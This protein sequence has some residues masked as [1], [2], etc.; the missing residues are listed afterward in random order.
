MRGGVRG[1]T[2][3]RAPTGGPATLELGPARMP[4]PY[5]RA[6]YPGNPQPLLWPRSGGLAGG[7]RFRTPGWLAGSKGQPTHTLGGWGYAPPSETH[8][9]PGGPQREIFPCMICD[10]SGT[11]ASSCMA[12][13][14]AGHCQ[15][16]S[17][18]TL[19]AGRHT[20]E[21]RPPAV[22]SCI[23]AFSGGPRRCTGWHD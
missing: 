4:S 16:L 20:P 15:R 1:G 7:W 19:S 9:L 17:M 11:Q 10:N 18:A 5:R 8:S 14:L 3:G 21:R 23:K 6:R 12:L 13:V 2:R 22:Q